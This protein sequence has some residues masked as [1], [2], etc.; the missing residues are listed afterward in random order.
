MMTRMKV[1][2]VNSTSC[3]PSQPSKNSSENWATLN[4][5][6]FQKGAVWNKWGK[7]VNSFVQC[8]SCLQLL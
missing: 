5:K 8:Q 6:R 7:L 3:S 1:P 2:A 4:I